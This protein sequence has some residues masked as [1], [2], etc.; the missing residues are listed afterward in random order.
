MDA[1]LRFALRGGARPRRPSPADLAC[2]ARQTGRRD[3]A[4]LHPVARVV[5]VCPHGCAA[6][7][8]CLPYDGSGRPFP[9]LF[10]ATCPTLVEAVHAVEGS[11]G[12]RRTER[13]VGAAG[14][15]ELIRSLRE[16][17]RYE[18]RRR[19]ALAAG[20]GAAGATRARDGGAVL[21][22]GIGGP[23]G[24]GLKCLHCHAAHALARPGY[25]LG[26][27]VLEG[28][29]VARGSLWCADARCLPWMR[30]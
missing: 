7:V 3:A 14:D 25:L 29:A 10:Y 11:G 6:A 30:P 5:A 16:A 4:Q 1:D 28:A 19:R 23:A 17:E 12:V 27:R 18:R 24:R 2:V 13:L 26:R 22:A 21:S 9:T 20:R 15:P 8:E